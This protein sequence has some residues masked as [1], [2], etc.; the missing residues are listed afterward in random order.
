MADNQETK[1]E[2]ANDEVDIQTKIKSA[3]DEAT[4]GLRSNRDEILNEKRELKEQLSK[5]KEQWSGLDSEQV[6]GLLKR[7]E[8]DREAKL[9]SEGKI[10][11]VLA[12]RT[13][14][15]RRDYVAQ[16]E[17]AQKR[18]V[19]LET[20]LQTREQQVAR[21]VITHKIRDEAT[22]A[23]IDVRALPDVELR[24]F[25]IFALNDNLEPV[26]RDSQGVL[27]VGKS[28]KGSLTI[29]EW[30]DNM[31]KEAPHWWPPSSGGGSVGGT[32]HRS[33]SAMDVN[34]LSPRQKLA[35]GYSKAT[36]G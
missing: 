8:S 14:A 28:G 2:N 17:A 26:A 3:V 6:R 30:L 29:A 27:V 5:L 35:Y 33:T 4:A 15:M 34:K 36:E 10:D 19:E 22:K 24:A 12:G 13:E 9:I 32:N 25:Q 16:S 7:F 23:G 11:E 1:T 18:L 21:L 31:K 20:S